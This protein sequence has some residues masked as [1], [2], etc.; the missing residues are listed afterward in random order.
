MNMKQGEYN[1][2]AMTRSAIDR[3]GLFD[4]NIYPVFYEDNDFQLR[5]TRMKPPLKVKVLKD[6]VMLHN[7]GTE[8]RYISG[9]YTH[10]A[11]DKV[12]QRRHT[13]YINQRAAF[14]QAYLYKKWGCR[15]RRWLLC[16]YKTPFNMSK[17]V[18]YWKPIKRQITPE[19]RGIVRR[20]TSDGLL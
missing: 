1:A 4:E 20:L 12:Y 6:V 2:F 8:G 14:S 19:H 17:P 7:K 18:W 11:L 3:F 10:D 13:G 15:N 5:Q 9:Q 16:A